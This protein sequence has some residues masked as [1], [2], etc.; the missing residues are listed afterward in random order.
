MVLTTAIRASVDDPAFR[1]AYRDW[2]SHPFTSR[3]LSL[4]R[5]A[6]D[7]G[8]LDDVRAESA[9]RYSGAVDAERELLANLCDLDG[10]V[11][12]R[13]AREKEVASLRTTYGVK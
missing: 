2:L 8:R 12:A 13:S 9:L 6:V 10:R 7:E 4:M 11:K 5:E 1:S 3:I